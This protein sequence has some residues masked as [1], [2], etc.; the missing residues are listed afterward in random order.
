MKVMLRQA[1]KDF[2]SQWAERVTILYDL[3]K[4]T[5][6]NSQWTTGDTFSYL[7]V[8]CLR[9]VISQATFADAST[10]NV[11]INKNNFYIPWEGY[12]FSENKKRNIWI[13]IGGQ[14]LF[15]DKVIPLV[16][17]LNERWIYWALI[18]K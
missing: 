10:A 16:P 18:Q 9:E 4:A 2:A 1:N 17:L 12:D 11:V 7:N 8:P 5:E 13:I 3:K 6:T 15:I 14:K